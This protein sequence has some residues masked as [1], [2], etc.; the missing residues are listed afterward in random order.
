MQK[1]KDQVLNNNFSQIDLLNIKIVFQR[2][3]YPNSRAKKW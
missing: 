2:T 3:K 1:N